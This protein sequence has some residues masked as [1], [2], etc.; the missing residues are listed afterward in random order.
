MDLRLE[1]SGRYSEA[2]TKPSVGGEGEKLPSSFGDQQIA[3]QA[4][5][6]SD[7]RER[8]SHFPRPLTGKRPISDSSYIFCSRIIFAMSKPT[9]Q[10]LVLKTWPWISP[11]RTVS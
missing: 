6:L 5:S 9:P 3:V 11:N 1:R 10:T 2:T 8:A 7:S 4:V